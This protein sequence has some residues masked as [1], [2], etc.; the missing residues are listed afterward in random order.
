MDS[1]HVLL[2]LQLLVVPILAIIYSGIIA[3]FG[4]VFLSVFVCSLIHRKQRP[5]QRLY[6]AFSICHQMIWLYLLSLYG[7][8]DDSMF[9][10]WMLDPFTRPDV[11]RPFV[12][13]VITLHEHSTAEDITGTFLSLRESSSPLL[14]AEV[15]VPAGFIPSGSPSIHVRDGISTFSDYVIFVSASTR[16]STGWLNGLLRELLS[17]ALRL[18]VPVIL[19]HG[20]RLLSSAMISSVR[21]ILYAVGYSDL[22]REVPLIPFFSVVGVSRKLLDLI[23][24]LPLLIGSGRMVEL[25]LRAWFC[26]NGISVS[27]FTVVEVKNP[28]V[29]DW[30]KLEG[31]EVDERISGCPRNIDWFYT[32]FSALDDKTSADM[33]LIRNSPNS[34]S[35]LGVFNVSDS[36]PLRLEPCD[37]KEDNQKFLTYGNST[38]LRPVSFP[39]LC[40]DTFEFLTAGSP[41]SLSQCIPRKRG[42]YFTFKSQR[43][44]S[45][46]FCLQKHSDHK[47]SMEICNGYGT[48]MNFLQMW[49]T[50]PVV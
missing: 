23:P 41:I 26:F 13:I 10:P 49:E 24:S 46:S 3:G 30:L 25:S 47:V 9:Q 27:R 38:G 33:F 20:D 21:G 48:S 45:G 34:D 2:I 22:S 1:F 17:D 39:Y 16:V 11:P 8:R 7:T 43:L 4:L 15:V 32:K 37:K 28:F 6:V 50:V 29:P 40:F 12:S 36:D 14:C 19:S 18:A 5:E 44:M 42:Q 31:E 35:C